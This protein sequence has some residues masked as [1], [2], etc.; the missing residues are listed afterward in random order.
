VKRTRV[1]DQRLDV[2]N[3]TR[4]VE[5]S[6]DY[7]MDGRLT[8]ARRRGFLIAGKRLRGC[9]LNLI[10]ARFNQTAEL[11]AANERLGAVTARLEDESEAIDHAASVLGDLAR[12]ASV[13]D[14]LV[15]V[16]ATFL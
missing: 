1:A 4:V 15:G 3:L 9:L 7:A 16:A 5:R 8:P 14:A 11:D 10:S 2:A 12:L 13:L 6:F